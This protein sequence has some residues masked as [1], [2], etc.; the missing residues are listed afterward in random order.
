M[1]CGLP[2]FFQFTF[3]LPMRGFLQ[4]ARSLSKWNYTAFFYVNVTQ[5]S[6]KAPALP[7]SAPG[8]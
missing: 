6:C 7:L 2:Y 5:V 1:L 4:I 8:Q 3:H